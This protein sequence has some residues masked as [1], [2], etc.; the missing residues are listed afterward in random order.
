MTN[1]TNASTEWVM[2]PRVPDETMWAAVNKLDDQMAAG[3]YDG[4]GCSIEQAWDCLIEAAPPAPEAGWISVDAQM[5]KPGRP[6]LVAYTTHH[7]LTRQRVN[8]AHWIP[9]KF[10]EADSESDNFEYDEATDTNW[11]PAC[12]YECLDHWDDYASVA[13]V[14]VTVTHWRPLPA[15]PAGINTTEGE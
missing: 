7:T 13:M 8:R 6:V 4:K 5:P 3:N 2:V 11:T 1:T 12:W 10:E 9:A 14:G 15:P